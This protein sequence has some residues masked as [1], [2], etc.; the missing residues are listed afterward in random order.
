[1]ILAW[2][3]VSDSEELSKDIHNL[4]M[5]PP[6]PPLKIKPSIKIKTVVN[7]IQAVK[8]KETTGIINV[9]LLF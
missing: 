8:V 5:P 7:S 2:T 4:H 9:G 6:Y 1:M 3:Y